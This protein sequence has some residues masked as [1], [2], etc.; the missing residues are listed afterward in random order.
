MTTA[1]MMRVMTTTITTTRARAV[2]T[3][4]LVAAASLCCAAASPPS[5]P[6]GHFDDHGDVGAVGAAGSVAI[7]PK[8]G[9][10]H[11]TGAG[12]NVWGTKDAF[13]FVWRKVGG[14]A[15]LTA[16][17]RFDGEG[18]NAHRKACLMVRQSLDADAPYADVAVHGDGLI[19]LQF[20]RE[21][22][23]PTQEIKS[24]VKAPATVRLAREGDVF[25]ML[26]APP[27]KA[28]EKEAQV[29]LAL[30]GPV[31]AGLA[32]CSHEAAVSETAVFS[33]VTA[34]GSRPRGG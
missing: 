32:V 3:A 13:H 25:T 7:D 30:A 28:L 24:K 9:D 16:D 5:P 31:Y 18:K 34:R 23:G 29:T 12:D 27:G 19:S 26:T 21:K 10:Y 2:L 6:L 1:G 17:V 15:S 4:R 8:T 33:N 20:R 22:G 14:D 11:V